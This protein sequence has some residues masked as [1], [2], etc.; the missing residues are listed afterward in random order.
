MSFLGTFL[1]LGTAVA[2]IT[3]GTTVQVGRSNEVLVIAADSRGAFSGEPA[4]N[5][6]CKI[7]VLGPQLAFA[8]VGMAG[9]RDRVGHKYSWSAIE[10]AHRA[11]S[12]ALHDVSSPEE[13]IARKTAD[14][15]AVSMETVI[16][17][18]I[19]RQPTILEHLE[20]SFVAGGVLRMPQS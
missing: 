12:R 2:Q 3:F 7:A 17:S 14:A 19:A 6:V 10:E 1:A 8:S 11:Y 13:D 9:E 5:T 4:D 18:V 20:S 15:W 16:Q